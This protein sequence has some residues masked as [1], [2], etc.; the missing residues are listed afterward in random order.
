MLIYPV[1]SFF[2]KVEYFPAQAQRVL[3]EF[4]ETK[5]RTSRPYGKS[6]WGEGWLRRMVHI[7]DFCI[8]H[9]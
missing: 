3:G 1:S 7:F 4:R 2:S 6:K 9:L 8:L 5:E